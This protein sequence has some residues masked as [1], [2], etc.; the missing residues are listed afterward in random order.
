M[1]TLYR[2]TRRFDLSRSHHHRDMLTKHFGIARNQTN[3]ES[4]EALC[5]SEEDFGNLFA[6]LI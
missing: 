1:L 4:I 6:D 5:W 2:E 3:I